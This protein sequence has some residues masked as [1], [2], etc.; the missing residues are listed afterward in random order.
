MIGQKFVLWREDFSREA[1]IDQMGIA[2]S[3]YIVTE[4]FEVI[5]T[6]VRPVKN[7][8]GDGMSTGWKGETKDGK[9]F[10]CNW[11]SFP[12]D[13]MTPTYYWDCIKDESGLWRPVDAEQAVNDHYVHVDPEGNQ[14]LPV[15]STVCEKHKVVYLDQ[16]WKCQYLKD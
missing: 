1:Y 7:M 6:E 3:G 9:V 11:H 13:S 2:H 8:W 14:K 4:E 10:T 15:G 5:I 16:C 12:D